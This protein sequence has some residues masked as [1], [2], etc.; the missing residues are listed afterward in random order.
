[1][2]QPEPTLLQRAASFAA[3]SADRPLPT[4]IADL[5]A[6]NLVD[7]FCVT[8]GARQAEPALRVA[9]V[10]KGWGMQGPSPLLTGG[11]GSPV[12]AALVNGTL[13]HCLDFDDLHFPS[14]S[15][16]SAPTWAAILAVAPAVGANERRMLEAFVTAFEVS[17]RLGSNGMGK[18]ITDRG[19]HSTGVHGRLSAAIAAGVLMGL[20]PGR[21][22]HAI[23][24]AATQTSGLTASFGTMAKPFHA[25]KAAMDGVLAAELA[26]AGF[27]GSEMI[28]DDE[29]SLASALVQD[30]SARMRLDG[31]GE[32]YELEH[33]ALKPYACCGLTHASIDCARDLSG[34]IGNHGISSVSVV[35]TPLASK[36]ANKRAP[37]TPLEGKF[38]T[39]F[40]VSLALRGHLASESD[41]SESRLEDPAIRALEA[42]TELLADD[43]LE[44]PA[45]RVSVLL[46]DG[47]RLDASVEVSLGNPE[48]PMRWPDLARKFEPLVEPQLGE[49]THSLFQTLR[50][51]QK[52]GSLR[53]ALE[54]AV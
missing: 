30:G 45:A 1:M 12:A 8:L 35:A 9:E 17:A 47:Q 21:M 27:Q 5:A 54:L 34:R 44:P 24:V 28:L 3:S 32:H 33:N 29:R 46:D 23:A 36:V 50:E 49:R 19:W 20:E 25:G 31:L 11:R 16:L 13:A 43:T 14:L 40:C 38:S 52:P 37:G 53:R 7:W 26:R 48:N 6:M 18:A 51:F 42:R 10:V 15:H 41:F 39:S 2:S 22:Q 4:H